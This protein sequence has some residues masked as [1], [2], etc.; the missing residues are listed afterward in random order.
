MAT[1][2]SIG[3]VCVL[4]ALTV[5]GL[6]RLH[7]VLLVLWHRRSAELPE[8]PRAWPTVTIQLPL[9]NEATV[10]A[11]L[12]DAVAAI[13]YPAERLEIQ[14]L[15]DSCDET[16]E[17]VDERVRWHRGLGVPIEVVRRPERTGFKAGALAY[18]LE[19]CEGDLIAIFDADFVPNPDFLRRTVPH[20]EDPQLG[21]VQGCWG[22]LNRD[23]NLLTRVQALALDAHFRIEQAARSRTGR[24]FNFNGTAGIWRREAIDGAGGWA[25][26]TITEDLDLSLR[27]QL[28]GWRFQFQ[29]DVVAPAELPEDLAA[30][31]AQQRRWTRGSGQTA[32]KLLGHVWRTPGVLFRARV[33]ATFQLLLNLAYP[34][35]LLLVLATVPLVA[36]GSPL[37]TLQWVLFGL[38]TLSV[39]LFYVV[40]QRHRGWSGLAEGLALT[41][42]LFAYG[43]GL[44]LSNGLAYVQGLFGGEAAFVRTP[45]RGAIGAIARRYSV[46]PEL[47]FALA[48]LGLAAY[49]FGGLG[50][51]LF[52]GH[53][54]AAPFLALIGLGFLAVG[55]RTL[56]P[57]APREM[58]SAPSEL[59]VELAEALDPET[60]PQPLLSS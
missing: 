19:R 15:D 27:A 36:L 60:A 57:A 56:F 7:L 9:Y 33:E 3:Y 31:R 17:I 6:H 52:L 50:Y 13:D 18:G 29:E 2:I 47:P 22:H 44:S 46:R 40:S 4:A 25:A 16:R 53:P 11:R 28:I 14:V 8:D 26:D 30:F 1:F 54:T 49:A 51:G 43:I 12:I 10:V 34:L 20:F 23:A 55:G 5:L 21:L 38:A 41:P 42:V 45:K 58:P 37:L 32:R 59:A 39:T 48:E 35:L 24:F